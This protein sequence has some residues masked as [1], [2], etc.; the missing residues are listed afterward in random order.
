[1][2]S[3][4]LPSSYAEYEGIVSRK[5]E[6]EAK[7]GPI[8]RPRGLSPAPVEMTEDERDKLEFESWRREKRAREETE[9]EA[10]MQAAASKRSIEEAKRAYD[11]ALRVKRELE[12]KERRVVAAAFGEYDYERLDAETQ[13]NLGLVPPMLESEA[14]V[15]QDLIKRGTLCIMDKESGVVHLAS[16]VMG[17]FGTSLMVFAER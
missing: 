15:I 3:S 9:Q 13:G 1:M 2:N 12:E 5:L 4:V 17:V 14:K 7:Q 16:G 6:F 11:E 10:A 8:E